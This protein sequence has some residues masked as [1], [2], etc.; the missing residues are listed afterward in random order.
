M[1]LE[2]DIRAGLIGY[3]GLAAAVAGISEAP[4]PQGAALPWVTFSRL[5]TQ[6]TQAFGNGNRIVTSKPHFQFDVWAATPASRDTVLP[7]LRAAIANMN[8]AGLGDRTLS[9]EQSYQEAETQLWRSMLS[10]YI[11]HT[12]A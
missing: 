9:T 7:L 3:A 2:T 10:V 4:L 5:S 1:S 8:F 6:R 12:G 11:G